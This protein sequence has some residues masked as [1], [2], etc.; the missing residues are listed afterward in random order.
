MLLLLF[1]GVLVY[2]LAEGSFRLL[3]QA[4]IKRTGGLALR[5]G[6]VIL[7]I[8]AHVAWILGAGGLALTAAWNTLAPANATITFSDAVFVLLVSIFLAWPI[9][10]I[11]EILAFSA[12][13]PDLAAKLGAGPAPSSD[14][15]SLLPPLEP[16]LATLASTVRTCLQPLE[17]EIA[18]VVREPDFLEHW[19]DLEEAAL[20]LDAELR[21]RT[22]TRK[23]LASRTARD[24]AVAARERLDALRLA[25]IESDVFD[26]ESIAAAEAR[27][28]TRLGGSGEAQG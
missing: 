7:A 28:A 13:R 14:S 27:R 3:V 15:L 5:P 12:G 22:V 24:F 9:L 10:F 23:L 2:L 20:A 11:L 1:G 17:G 16:E 8:T 18:T 6:R 4:L 26:S 21:E 19:L 25:A